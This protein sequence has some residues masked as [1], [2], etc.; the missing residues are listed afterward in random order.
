MARSSPDPK[1]ETNGKESFDGLVYKDLIPLFEKEY[2]KAYPSAKLDEDK[3]S[4]EMCLKV[5][6]RLSDHL[7]LVMD[8]WFE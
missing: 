5:A 2:E 3:I 8:V 4:L 7:P 1:S 6:N